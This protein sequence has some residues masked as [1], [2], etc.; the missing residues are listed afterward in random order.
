A[1]CTAASGAWLEGV[2]PGTA[3]PASRCYLGSGVLPDLDP[4]CA[5]PCDTTASDT[6]GC[7]DCHAPG[8]D[9]PLGGRSLLEATGLAFTEGV[10]CDVCHKSERVDLTA[11]PGVAGALG[12]LR[13]SEEPTITGVDWQPLTFGPLPDVPNPRMGAVPR[14]HFRTAEL[15][16]A[17]HELTQGAR[18]PGQALDGA[19]WPDGLPVLSTYS[20]WSE[21]PYAPQSPCQSCHMP[22]ET[23]FRN[24]ADLDADA[25]LIDAAT[26]WPR[27]PGATRRHLW[28]GPR[29][30]GPLLGLAAALDL[31]TSVVDDV[32]TVDVTTT[33]VGAGHAL[34]TGEPMRAVIL[35]VEARCDGTPLVPT[36]GDV[37]PA[38]GGTLDART[39]AEGWSTWPGA[40][41][42][43]RIR[44]VE[45]GGPRDYP[46]PL[47]F[48]D[49]GFP[50]GAK[51]LSVETYVG[52][53]TVTAVDGDTVT[54]DVPLPAGDLAWR[55]DGNGLPE[56]GE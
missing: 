15:C 13:P 29:G 20:E 27:A 26:G 49:G 56:D 6:G 18:I 53:S 2:G 7:A 25:V 46:G 10:H 35:V 39:A 44:V 37:V 24:A 54:L 42:G 52:G 14:D 34:P 55:A 43:D 23:R 45:V 32:L 51:G 3:A 16:A 5:P 21:G 8:I 17:C 36:G 48:G 11:P 33:N 22:P 19:R 41:V 31:D 1:S 38:F 28:D 47:R 9:G 4:T 50:V 30:D 40:R 12:I